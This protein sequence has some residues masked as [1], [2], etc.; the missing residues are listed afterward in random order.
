MSQRRQR[1][2]RL[3]LDEHEKNVDES[4]AIPKPAKRSRARKTKKPAYATRAQRRHQNKTTDLIPKRRIPIAITVTLL[5]ASVG[6]L[7]LLASLRISWSE[8]LGS[9]NALSLTGAGTLS[10]WFSSFLLILSGLASLQIY[11]LRQHRNDDYRGTYRIW[12]WMA[13][14]FVL[15][16]V[17][18]VINF[19]HFF[20]ALAGAFMEISTTSPKRMFW[21]LF[22]VKLLALTGLVIR[23]IFEVRASKGALTMV[24]LVWF[25]YAASIVIQ[26]PPAKEAIVS[27]FE[28]VYGNCLLVGTTCLLLFVLVYARYVFLSANG[29]LKVKKVKKA[30]TAK[31]KSSKPKMVKQ[32]ATDENKVVK[33]TEKAK[34]VRIAK[35]TITEQ[36]DEVEQQPEAEPAQPAA[37]KQSKPSSPL[38]AKMR[39]M[40]KKDT[41]D[42]EA[43]IISLMDK[44]NLSKSDKRRLK[45]LE[46]RVEQ[47][48]AA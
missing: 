42:E 46:K 4:E 29:L 26:V 38:A 18:S 43:E 8:L 40:K 14:I 1:V 12:L 13:G 25:A 7:N 33:S 28:T 32:K 48:R 36:H 39:S 47:R 41:S 20:T 3:A 15:A 17:N 44:Q 30:V 2:R 45:K 22:A 24:V 35:E 31:A 9:S 19:G 10:G 34:P 27:N 11:A 16:S 37:A 23:G 6:V 21:W 5:A